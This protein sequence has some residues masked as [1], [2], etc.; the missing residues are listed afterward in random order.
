MRRRSTF[1]A[2]LLA[3]ILSVGI[4]VALP[5]Y[6]QDVDFESFAET[7]GFSTTAS[8]TVIIA[9]LIRT[10]ITLVGVVTVV[11]LVYGGFVWMTS[12]G[13]ATRLKK[14]KDIITNAI[15]GLL[16][17][18][19][20]FAIVSFVLNALVGA[21]GGD[22]SGNS[23]SGSGSYSDGGGGSS[24]YLSSVNT[25]CAEALQNLQLQFIFSKKVDAD[26]IEEGIVIEDA[27]G[28]VVEGTFSTSS[29]TVI[30]TPLQTCDSP[31]EDEFC[32]D[33]LASYT[34]DVDSTII[35]SSSGASLTCTTTYPCSF[36]F[37]TGSAID[38]DDPT[39][40]MDAPEDGESLYVGSIEL[41]Q[42]LTA[43]DSGVSTVDFY[44]VV[45]D[46]AIYSS[47]VDYSSAGT[48]TGENVENAFFTDTAEEWD[49]EGYTTNEEYDI[50]ATG[51]DCAGNTDTASRVTV[52]LRAANCNNEVLDEDLGETD[53]DCGGDSSSAYYCGSCDGDSCTENSQCASGQCV[54]GQCVTTPKIEGVSPGDGAVDNL[55]TISGEGFG[56][57]E[58]VLT[59]LGT[60]LGDEV[61]V[62]AYECNA[63]VQWSDSEIIVQ[64]PGAAID[65]P[66][67]VTT[68]E[69]ETERTDDDY[70]P[71]I[72]D[73]DVNAIARPGICLLDP[74][75]DDYG[76]PI[77]VYGN[78]FGEEQGSSTFYF[79]NYEASSYVSWLDD[80]LE[81][82]V[83]NVNSGSYR[84]QVFTGDF[85]CIDAEGSATA[86][87]CSDDTDC[88]TET[89]ESCATSWCSETL[90]YCETDD[91]CGDEEGSC[92]SIRVG[93]NEVSFT[94]ADV[95][96]DSTP[97]ISSIDSG[98]KACSDDN[99]HCGDDDDCSE[100]A[101]CDDA[102]NWGPPGQYITIYGTGFGTSTG[103][104]FFENESLGYTALG[105]TDF[106]DACGDDFWHDTYVTVKVPETYQTES[107]D[108]IEAIEHALT[109]ERADGVDSASVDFVVLDDTPGPA[110]CDVDPS[111]GPADTEVTIYG[112]NFG[113]DDGTVTFYSIQ[114]ADYSLW[115][116]DEISS[117]VVPDEAATGPVYVEEAENGYSSNSITFT[118]GD[119]R[120]EAELCDAEEGTSCCSDGSCSFDC[121]ERDEVEAHY[122]FMI[123]TGI[124][125]N[126]PNVIVSCTESGV[127]PTP[128]E[129]WS[130]PEDVCVT[131]SVEAEFDM[132]MDQDT[133]TTSTVIVRACTAE[134]TAEEEE[135]EETICSFTG[136]S[137]DDDDDCTQEDEECLAPREGEC[138]NW[139]A[140][141]GSVATDET[142]FA[143][144]PTDSFETS[145]LYRVTLQGE[146]QIA[147][148]D[149]GYMV[150]DYTW[151]FTTSSSGAPCEVGDVN[152]RPS[153]YT[154]TE[155][156]DVDY[157]A[158]LIAANDLCVA[159]SCTGYT[160]NWESDFDG[161]T[162][163]TA[164]PGA[165]ICTNEVSAVDETPANDPA[166]ITATV[167]NAEND[168]SDDGYLTINFLDPEIDDYFPQ[169]S[170]ACVNALPWGEF[171]TVMSDTTI[172]A[173]SV[174]LYECLNSLCETSGLDEVD[175]VD[176][177]S[178]SSTTQKFY[179]NFE[180]EETMDPNTWYRVVVD[181]DAVLSYTGVALSESGSNYGTDENRYFE[182]DFSWR[183]K[184]KDSSVSCAIDSVT[185]DPELAT[186]TYIGERAEFD[187]TGQ[188]A[189]DDCSAAGQTLQSG[190]YEWEAWTATDSPNNVGGT[191]GSESAQDEIVAYMISDG[192]IG[193]TSSIPTYCTA[194]CLNAGAPVTT[195][196]GV[197]GNG[198]IED[199][200][201]CDDGGVEDDDGCSSVCLNEGSNSTCGDGD[202]DDGEDC[203]D[204][205][206]TGGD[207]C[208]S[209]CL[210]EGSRSIGATCGDGTQDWVANTGGEDCDDGNS[211]AGDGCSNNCLLEGSTS[212]EDVYAVCGD[213]TVDDGEDCDP[214]DWSAEGDGCSASCLYE[215]TSACPTSASTKCC[216]N[217]DVETGEECDGEEGCSSR[218]LWAGS[219]YSYS[220]SSFCGD[221]DDTG[222]GE[223][224]DA[225]STAT[226]SVGD[227]GVG[228]VATGAPEEVNESTG[229]AISTVSVTVDGDVTGKATLQLQCACTTDA[230]CGVTGIGCGDKNCCY[231]RP[232]LVDGQVYPAENSGTLEAGGDGYCRNTAIWLEFSQMMDE[233][234]FDETVDDDGDGIDETTDG[235]G[236][237][238]QNEFDA[239]LYLDLVSVDSNGDGTQEKID[240]IADCPTGYDGASVSS[241]TSAGARF[242]HW[243]K[244]LVLGVFGREAS[245]S[246]TFACHV[247]V[248]YEI[249]Q[250]TD[251]S[252]RAYLRYST[253]LEENAVYRLV[254][255]GDDNATDLI[256][257]GVLSEDAVTLCLGATCGDD[258]FNQKFE[259]G[260]DIC[261]L[262]RVVV[263][264]LGDVDA[265][266]YEDLSIQYFSSTGEEHA[267]IATPQTYRTGSGY[268][269][270][271]ALAGVYGWNWAWTSSKTDATDGDVVAAVAE[272]VEDTTR[273]YTASGSTGREHV[274]STATI[275][276]DKLFDPTTAATI[277]TS[278]R[279]VSGTLEVTAL[280][281]ENP[282][283]SLTSL[284]L[285]FPYLEDVLPSNFS[286]YYCRDAGDTGID[287]DLPG[288]ED[289]IDVSSLSS[290]G[291][292]Q[293]LIFKVEGSR[294]AIGVRVL[295]N[296]GYLTPSA[297][298]E[299]QDF[300]GSFHETG[301]D[302]YPAVEAG[303]TIYAA[304]ANVN[305]TTIYP[306][307][308]IVSYNDNASEDA[309][310]IFDQ[311]L[312]NWRFN[313]NT[314][315]VTDVNLCKNSSTQSYA[316]TDAGD[317]VA[318]TWD[319][320]CYE[321]FSSASIT[322]DAQKGKLT[323]DMTRLLDVVDMATT[324][325]TFGG[326]NGHC[327]VTKGQSCV[328]DAECPGSEVCVSGFPEVQSG[329]F[330]P[331]L[332]N[333]IWSSWNASLANELGTALPTDP[334]NEFYNCSASGYDAAS[335][336]N[337]EKG[338]FICPENSHLYGYQSVGGEDYLLYAVLESDG[339]D[340]TWA[341]D[342][343]TGLSDEVTVNAEYPK[344]YAPASVESGFSI[345]PVFCDGGTWGDSSVCGDGT[346]GSTEVCEIGDTNVI[347]CTDSL[348]VAGLITVACE[349]DCLGYQTEAEAE[350]LNAQC[351]PYR[352][353]NGVIETGETC[354]DGSRNGTY[355][356][357]DD[358]CGVGDAFYC[359]DGYLAASEQ[360]DCGTT[361][362]YATVIADSSSWASINSCPVSNGQYTDD[363]DDSCSYNCTSPG[364]SCGD[365]RV[366][367]SEEC[368]G[369]YEDWEGALCSDGLTTCVSDSDC[370]SGDTCGDTGY[371]SA[372]TGSVCE[373]GA[374]AGDLCTE[375]T[376]VADCGSGID[377]SVNTYD[378]F[379]YRV[380]SSSCSWP[381]TWTGPVGGDQQCGNGIVEGDEACDDGN[382][383]NNDECLN[384]CVENVCGDDYVYV[385]SESCDDG[386]A[387]GTVCAAGYEDTCN[388][389][390]TTCQY[391]TA[392]GGY[393]GDGIVDTGETCDGG[394]STQLHY[395]DVSTG[396]TKGTCE[397]T[398]EYIE[399]DDGNG[400]F[401]HWL[402]VCNGGSENGEYCTFD[403]DGW[404]GG[405]PSTLSDNTG[406]DQN[407]CEGGK[408]VPPLCSADCGSSC[409]LGLETVGLLIQS[410]ASGAQASD[411]IS[412]YS[413]LNSEGD[414]PDNA[415][416]FIPACNVATKLTADIDDTDVTPPD[417]DIVFVTDLSSSMNNT[418][419]DARQIDLA[420]DS[421]V[422]AIEEL[423][424]AYHGS[425]ALMQIGLV[426]YTTAYSSGSWSC[427]NTDREMD[428]AFIDSRL[429]DDTSESSLVSLVESYSTCVSG[430]SGSTPT[431]NGIKEAV[432]LLNVS[433]TADIKIIVVLTDGDFDW[434]EGASGTDGWDETADVST[435]ES[436]NTSIYT[437]S[438]NGNTYTG[439]AACAADMHDDFVESDSLS[440]LFYT[441]A[442]TDSATYYQ[443]LTEHISSNDCA[444]ED[445]NSATDLDDCTGNYAFFAQD[446]DDI[447]T[448]YESIV[449]SI[450]GSNV[451][452]TATDNDGNT[453]ITTGE[454]QTGSDVEFPF[455]EGF[456]C[457]SVEQTIPVRN[458][459][460]GSGSLFYSDF[461]M[462][463]CPYE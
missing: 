12:G 378:L 404:E 257:D 334:I 32:F 135:A 20:S 443:P 415:A 31:Y 401:C 45:D 460:Y 180:D 68:S 462:T 413:Y 357:C 8:I 115:E 346:Q 381:L 397:D 108:A 268:E 455:P 167:T 89:G 209:I 92:E 446:E 243:I 400:Y 425:G 144:S 442:I 265:T 50:W 104:I 56:G 390:N 210:N 157:S 333:S 395:F 96:S 4:F 452:F 275:T 339:G 359:G 195:A 303:N 127:S 141:S 391:K 75:A 40:E 24:F 149:S 317:Y 377:C 137:C 448:M 382:S 450:L 288:L 259:I 85:V 234:T 22:I 348:G 126:T 17:V 62:S 318:C 308:Y 329:T 328:T 198:D 38:I 95:S 132:A 282:W 169:C 43:D 175:F 201:E 287:D 379:R 138:K 326:L 246:D 245:A 249:S 55:I 352:C 158:Q 233:A 444:W 57:E 213:G 60:E 5:T 337:G 322:C 386:D 403:Y 99:T 128:W 83:P 278:A 134:F 103:S 116:N 283:P 351:E 87:T 430:G 248:T 427:N 139:E 432:N 454:V 267:F 155:Q 80:Q 14:A 451:S 125:P 399:D 170:T 97:I 252:M 436:C 434:I 194:A 372:G 154:E 350:A 197:C 229:Y 411:S 295:A 301:L 79:T 238:Q 458:V 27:G 172:S 384:I 13:D 237:I 114:E 304:A 1:F 368:D 118:V 39:V 37:T 242:W 148:E 428:G 192:A 63:E 313:G 289:P 112:E 164:E 406:Y 420:V 168:P 100:G 30:F 369:D 186:M 355:G 65:G 433:S 294:D 387:N 364:L 336:W 327:E 440:I 106:P 371:E 33:A 298:V 314:N 389:C 94:V 312:L 393:C 74:S 418:L 191:S 18:F 375:A 207:G 435:N 417:V 376:K 439:K 28:G 247:P 173:S 183:F 437:K 72:A 424:D 277:T 410:E 224:C 107:L 131:A 332:S 163:A 93:S 241:A 178:Y 342:L 235:D 205:N 347:A 251:G 449:D 408:C 306:N 356:H 250:N 88:D 26:T 189:P 73:F 255:I 365:G 419:G 349:S 388:Y 453:T 133:I 279:S 6:A 184:T 19:A 344:A 215:G 264:D 66:I 297:W 402:G 47:G 211:A 374:N 361:S 398:Y 122:A 227:Y 354:D 208:S 394:Y 309:Q 270:I 171:N 340:Y 447:S 266:E 240:E 223:E 15:I 161:A 49:T 9:R 285:D 109:L 335:C 302:G 280:V 239:N 412:L 323:R 457:Q 105:D 212:E 143:W 98:W 217:D 230:S 152:V 231:E 202:I 188:G 421:T 190:S 396:T 320:D 36:S 358:V 373:S 254:V 276:V 330:V 261:D 463:Y 262:D 200:E 150:E 187:A 219:S 41:V 236:I 176:S 405:T 145:T 70:G 78:S 2:L 165:G 29:R 353:G 67:S 325:D 185:L 147:S 426:S 331:A 117:V 91:D 221:G 84:T 380:C 456:V 225:L 316:T 291:I 160:L 153:E 338:T 258:V 385:G 86:T 156:T 46:E 281:C 226:L 311:V 146:D 142:G 232:T 124:T 459:F 383:S 363:P 81:V 129:G 392:S 174:T 77:D 416:L 199:S 21:T 76:S 441:A 101:T 179:I 284:T 35:E 274:L 52:V 305:A 253:L 370:D 53:V 59:F 438:Y 82:V 177:I 271:S 260:E 341:Y 321:A 292:I 290:S 48:L 431:Y 61:D 120:E 461:T 319:G 445:A 203:D 293:E 23:D 7:A 272:A 324:I 315:E 414:S 102:P 16:L 123:T 151:E 366:N 222:I 409:P 25:E 121:G 220:T 273:N 244:S 113:T 307:M 362:T 11:F 181:G 136:T 10:A 71:S 44:V 159:V 216:G 64:V 111:A 263:E 110:I 90:D 343:D 300:T 345:A 214:G 269:E 256:K 119:C 193:L 58:G 299:E 407:S 34:I 130:Q 196:E 3:L 182:D 206:T 69:D 218:C 429:V 310:D 228:Q 296:E 204:S 42:A 166:R 367:G 51:Y 54:D 286:F 422:E 423:F 162:I 140:V 360:C